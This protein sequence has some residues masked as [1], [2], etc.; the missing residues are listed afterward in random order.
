MGQLSN[1]TVLFDSVVNSTVVV[2]N[3]SSNA[4]DI[5]KSLVNS[6]ISGKNVTENCIGTGS[7]NNGTC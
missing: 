7:G 4:S 5:F 6:S 3:V 1:S 2:V